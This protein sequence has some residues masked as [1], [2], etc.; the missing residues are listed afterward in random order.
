MGFLNSATQQS[1]N[2]NTAGS[3]FNN[4]FGLVV[5]L[6]SSEMIRVKEKVK[7]V[8]TEVD[9]VQLVG[10]ALNGNDFVSE[11][12]TVVV[13]FR[14]QQDKAIGNLRKGQ[15]KQVLATPEGVA[16]STVT[17]EGC[18]AVDRDDAGRLKINSRW[19]NTLTVDNDP[20]HHNR[21]F[22][23]GSYAT[24]PRVVF[25]NPE[26]MDGEPES[27]TFPA[28][29][30]EMTFPVTVDG[31][32]GRATFSRDWMVAKLN[33]IKPDTDLT[34]TIDQVTPQSAV[35]VRSVEDLRSVLSEQLATGTRSLALLRVSDGEDI[36]TR[37]LYV[38][39]K[40]EGDNYVPDIAKTLADLEAKNIFRGIPNEA[41]WEGV[42]IGAVTMESIP[43]YRLT[44]AGNPHKDDNAAFK[45]VS[46][47]KKGTGRY[48]VVFGDDPS[49]LTKVIL[50][51]IARTQGIGGFSPI[52][53]I[54]DVPGNFKPAE[55]ATPI[56]N[57]RAAS[58]T[59]EQALDAEDSDGDRPSP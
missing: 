15:G 5:K 19:I 59:E 30:K 28:N 51:G 8:E 56:I 14:G 54:T 25:K 50:P 10:V 45:L 33:A 20:A 17:L 46:D 31:A 41:L 58:S 43:G 42:R 29:A 36:K 13:G 39:F 55:L 49:A 4:T 44:Y 27:I 37:M 6:V 26:R 52:N 53:V 11:G 1:Q 12:E 18:Y 34:V 22:V 48:E 35:Q 23:D 57:P 24:A 40:K 7:D 3:S 21:S 16:N 32:K 38:S 9:G 2:N 47:L